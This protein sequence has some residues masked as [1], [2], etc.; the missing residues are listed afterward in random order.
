MASQWAGQLV[1]LALVNAV[2][3]WR[4][5]RNPRAPFHQAVLWGLAAV[6]L[7]AL[8]SLTAPAGLGGWQAFR[9]SVQANMHE[10]LQ[11]AEQGS[12]LKGA[13]KDKVEQWVEG[14]FMALLPAWTLV[15]G[16]FWLALDEFLLHWL[17]ERMGK[18][19]PRPPL[20][21][22]VLPEALIWILL[23]SGFALLWM[24]WQGQAAG[25]PMVL[26]VAGNALVALLPAYLLEGCLVATWQMRR[27]RFPR[28]LRWS[29]WVVLVFL[30]GPLTAAFLA[31][32]AVVGIMDTWFDFRKVRGL[33]APGGGA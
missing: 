9:A 21:A 14:V 28:W 32:L 23:A 30:F 7:A 25:H 11:K 13:E 17:L 22:W 12:G 6:A 15:V 27:W 8:P 18:I 5:L 10:A 3:A 33:G 29:A 2:M 16:L 19:P 4:I 31:L 1:M 20:L 26:K 24:G